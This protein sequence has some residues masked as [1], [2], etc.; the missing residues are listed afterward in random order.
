MSK[1]REF[2]VIENDSEFHFHNARP[3]IDVNSENLFL[4]REVLP[5]DDSEKDSVDDQEQLRKDLEE[6][7][8]TYGIAHENRFILGWKMARNHNFKLSMKEAEQS[9]YRKVVDWL[10]SQ[11]FTIGYLRDKYDLADVCDTGVIAHVIESH[12]IKKES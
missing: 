4:V 9:A 6:Y 5:I 7:R 2:W 11:G 12:F 1:A 8:N 10:N 3:L